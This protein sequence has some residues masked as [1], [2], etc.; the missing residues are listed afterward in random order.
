M[1]EH[2]G[3]TLG[4]RF[5]TFWGALGSIAAVA[6]LVGAYRLIVLPSDKAAS[7]GGAGDIRWNT[8]LTTKHAEDEDY[9]KVAEVEAGKTVRL[10]AD[11][12][13]PYAVKVLS[14]HKAAPSAIKTPEG[15]IKASKATHDPS[16]SEFEKTPG[17]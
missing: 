16:L 9:S 6:V 12:L 11:T 4:K 17:N 5:L 7:D 10:P 15:L 3:D 2:P 13:L 1:D 14:S 8:L